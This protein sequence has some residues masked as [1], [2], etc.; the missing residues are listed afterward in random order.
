MVYIGPYLPAVVVIYA[1]GLVVFRMDLQVCCVVLCKKSF[2]IYRRQKKVLLNKIKTVVKIYY[3][4]RVGRIPS[5]R[6]T[7]I[8]FKIKVTRNTYKGLLDT[9]TEVFYGKYYSCYRLRHSDIIIKW[10]SQ[11]DCVCKTRI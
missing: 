2:G 9:F 6:P 1:R 11:W 5:A 4:V 3:H 10:N 8:V 7:K